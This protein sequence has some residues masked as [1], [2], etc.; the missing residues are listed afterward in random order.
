MSRVARLAV[1]LLAGALVGCTDQLAAP[2]QPGPQDAGTPPAVV[3]VPLPRHACL[4][5]GFQAAPRLESEIQQVEV[6][7][8]LPHWPKSPCVLRALLATESGLRNI[9]RVNPHS[10]ALGIAQATKGAAHDFERA[11]G[12]TGARSH[13]I[14]GI[15][16][17]G[18]RLDQERRG[19]REPRAAEPCRRD[20]SITG[21]YAGRGWLLKSQTAA[22]RDG[23]T[24]R[25]LGDGIAAH[26]VAVAP[27]PIAEHAPVYLRR[28][29]TYQ[30]RMSP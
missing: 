8:L 20:L 24:A 6:R 21:Y 1:T 4:A 22:R 30:K 26:L 18:W 10:S 15:R 23:N 17:A 7:T 3:A 19:W 25:C 16:F 29:L 5:A 27:R 28:V 9:Q 14:A 13:P 11:T 12:I 2:P